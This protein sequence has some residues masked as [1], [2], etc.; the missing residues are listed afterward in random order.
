[1]VQLFQIQSPKLASI[2]LS[3][4]LQVR[5]GEGWVTQWKM[6]GFF[7]LKEF[8]G[9]IIA[10]EQMRDGTFWAF[11]IAVMQGE[12]CR[13]TPYR[14]RLSALT[15]LSKSFPESIK[16]IPSG[17]GSEFL[18]A[19]LKAGGEGVVFKRLGTTWGKGQYKCKR[20]ETFDAVV[21]ARNESTRSLS[22]I[23]YK[24]GSPLDCGNVAS[25]SKEEW[26][27][28]KVGDVLEIKCQC[29]HKSGKFREPRI[30]R[31]R[32]DKPAAECLA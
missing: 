21:S 6:D 9:C 4:G 16:L 29:R 11:D 32:P 26:E 18:E 31:T 8:N 7:A 23:Q 24:D 5:I 12:D 15:S 1:M 19:V 27:T 20:E 25:L 28:I 14:Y 30:F 2:P 13:Q 10:G 3:E 17:V 22:L